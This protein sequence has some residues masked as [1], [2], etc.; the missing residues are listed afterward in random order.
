MSPVQFQ[1]RLRLQ[2][3]RRGLPSADTVSSVA[4]GVGYESISLFNRDYRRLFEVMPSD[5]AA[6]LRTVLAET[7]DRQQVGLAN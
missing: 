6:R 1:K 7:S 5:D 2:E 4:Y 3:A